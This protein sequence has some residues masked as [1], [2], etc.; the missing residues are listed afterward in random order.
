MDPSP[1]VVLATRRSSLADG[2]TGSD[3]GSYFADVGPLQGPVRYDDA[4]D[5]IGVREALEGPTP[6]GLALCLGWNP[7]G[8]AVWKLRIHGAD[9]SG[10]WV[11]VDREFRRAW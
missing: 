5:T 3:M 2:S 7:D 6:I 10:R 11:L 4:P 8:M 9:V 1:G